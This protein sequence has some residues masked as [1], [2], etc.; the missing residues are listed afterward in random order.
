MLRRDPHERISLDG[1]LV[2]LWLNSK[3][4]PTVMLKPLI[5]KEE[6]S[7]ED[8]NKI[9]DRMVDGKIALREEIQT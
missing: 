1:I 6:I 7:E 4:K 8:S 5:S 2:H 9:I 3:E